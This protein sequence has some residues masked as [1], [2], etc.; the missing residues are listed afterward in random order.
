MTTQEDYKL[1]KMQMT[2]RSSAWGL[3]NEIIYCN[4]YFGIN[5]LEEVLEYLKEKMEESR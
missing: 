1:E 2:I 5:M 4:D 3:S